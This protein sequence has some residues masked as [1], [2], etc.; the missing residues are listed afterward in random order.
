MRHEWAMLAHVIRYL[1]RYLQGAIVCWV[2]EQVSGADQFCVG[3]L[4]SSSHDSWRAIESAYPVLNVTET[5]RHQ[6]FQMGTTHP[7]CDQV[8]KGKRFQHF[9]HRWQTMLG[10]NN[11]NRIILSNAPPRNQ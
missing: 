10:A 11:A 3:D 4:E 6:G 5:A 8:W 9:T 1:V 2:T 7:T